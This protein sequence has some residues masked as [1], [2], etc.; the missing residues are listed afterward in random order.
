MKWVIGFVV[1]LVLVAVLAVGVPYLNN[2]TAVGAG[3]VAKEVCSCM[4]LGGRD[5]AACRADLPESLDF[6]RVQSEPLPDGKGV[7]AWVPLFAERVALAT[8][9]SGCVLQP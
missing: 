2:V 3:Y 9:E 7:R 4:T 8:P 6:E 1:W 5:Y